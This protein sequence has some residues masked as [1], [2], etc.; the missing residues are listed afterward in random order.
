MVALNTPEITERFCNTYQW[1]LADSEFVA[2][3]KTGHIGSQVQ[4]RLVDFWCEAPENR[5]VT[6]VA[7]YKLSDAGSEMSESCMRSVQSFVR[8]TYRDNLHTGRALEKSVAMMLDDDARMQT[9][10][11]GWQ[12]AEAYALTARSIMGP[13]LS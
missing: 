2:Y 7:A 3:F 9:L 8:D 11:I 6:W 10:A 12:A 5:F 13:N 4:E 1:V